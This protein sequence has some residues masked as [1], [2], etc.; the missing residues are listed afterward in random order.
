VFGVFGGSTAFP[1]FDEEPFS[2][3]VTLAAR[4]PIMARPVP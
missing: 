2:S 1:V 3:Q 4:A